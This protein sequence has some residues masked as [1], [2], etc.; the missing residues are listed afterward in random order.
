M[1]ITDTF[2]IIQKILDN[3]G[4][5]DTHDPAI[6]A[7]IY[8]GHCLDLNNRLD[9]CMDYL[10]K[11]MIFKALAPEFQLPSLVGLCEKMGRLEASGWPQLCSEKGWQV[12]VPLNRNALNK[13]K[14]AVEKEAVIAP[15]LKALRRANNRGNARQCTAVLREILKID[16][17]NAGWK[18]QLIEFEKYRLQQ[19]PGEFEALKKEDNLNEAA[20]L[21]V[22]LKKDWL[23]S[24]DKGLVQDVEEFVQTGLK[25]I[26]KGQEKSIARKMLEAYEYRDMEALGNAVEDWE[27]LEKNQSFKA[28]EA[29]KPLYDEAMTW[30]RQKLK[31]LNDRKNRKD[32][33]SKIDEKIAN[34]TEQGIK[35]LWEKLKGFDDPMPMGLEEKIQSIMI[36]AEQKR[37]RAREIKKKRNFLFMAAAL[38]CLVLLSVFFYLKG[39]RSG[40]LNSLDQ[41]FTS[42]D[43]P[44]FNAG[45]DKMTSD[46]SFLF[47]AED[48]YKEKTRG[49]ELAALLNQKK[50]RYKMLLL[51]LE[52]T[53]SKGFMEPFDIIEDLFTRAQKG[54]KWLNMEEKQR[55]IM[56]LT[57]WN[58]R[59]IIMKAADEKKMAVILNQLSDA[60]K[61]M[62]D[63][64]AYPEGGNGSE[65]GGF[66]QS[67]ELLLADAGNLHMPLIPG[68]MKEQLS[69]FSKKF[70]TM[71]S[72]LKARNQHIR[73]MHNADTLEQYLKALKTFTKDFPEDP[74][75]LVVEPVIQM[76]LIYEDLITDPALYDPDNLFWAGLW[77][78]I[79]ELDNNI[80]LH[81]DEVMED[82][83][84]MGEDIQVC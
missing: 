57:H 32:I 26:L 21:M 14:E 9:K 30:H 11:G 51:R 43:M 80:K 35:E 54:R 23:I 49:E 53:A 58:Q 16:P 7:D 69:N 17:E 33:L 73:K 81:M 64:P 38:A 65:G 25:V 79:K 52:E 41:A 70:K 40:L 6:M 22:E 48:V 63:T 28:D 2:K 37:Q 44:G 18:E 60:F 84:K 59:K 10:Q 72:S 19:I 74:M 34:R 13:L 66:F 20:K 27:N 36:D 42:E 15:L 67:I 62:P 39:I 83:K 78:N 5:I 29:L 12:P 77:E 76:A 3:R 24:V 55:L 1:K 82:L 45:L 31:E 50:T 68:S 4:S 46:Y 8:T 71:Q 61:N 56:A 47:R 75:S